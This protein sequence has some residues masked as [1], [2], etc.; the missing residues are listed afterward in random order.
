MN[1]LGRIVGL[2]DKSCGS[3]ALGRFITEVGP[4]GRFL[5]RQNFV[6][7]PSRTT[8]VHTINSVELAISVVV[9]DEDRSGTPVAARCQFSRNPDDL[10]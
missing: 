3:E 8:R 5:A 6:G 4:I 1:P 7:G 2:S 9:R 10:D